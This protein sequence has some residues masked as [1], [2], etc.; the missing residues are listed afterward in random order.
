MGLLAVSSV[1]SIYAAEEQFNDALR[2]ANSGNVSALEQYRSSMQN[3]ALGYYPE[4]WQLNANL[5]FQPPNNIANFAQ[6]YPQSAMAEK[7]SADYVEEKVK[8]A[9]FANAQSILQYVSNAD[10]A[11]NCA[12]AQVRA[13]TG[14]SLVFAEY[15][16]VW[17]KTDSQPESCQG[18]GRLMLS[19]PLLTN[20]D[21]QQRLYA[22]L[23]AGQSGQ[24][25]ATA[26]T[27]GVSLSLA[28]LNQIQAD[29]LNYL[30]A[31]PKNNAADHAYLVFAIGRAANTD[32][33]SA[34]QTLPKALQGVPVD[35]QKYLN[36][37]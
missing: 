16:D 7:L 11:E 15:K 24:A 5:A 28:Q 29:P 23:R 37:G 32:L 3:D 12:I 25:I 35:V 19:S 13:K 18:L 31:A 2:L 17:L 10:Q 26:Q 36:R 1:S 33:T 27:L 6:R 8:Q 9:D 21:R 4:Y 20:V 22:L 34:I 30:W 14:D